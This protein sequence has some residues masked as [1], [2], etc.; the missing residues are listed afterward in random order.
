LAVSTLGRI[1]GELR[2][3]AADDRCIGVVGTVR[4]VGT[5]YA[6]I[7]L[8]RALAHDANVV[9]VDLAFNTPNLSVISNNPNAPGIAELMRETASFDDVIA[10]DLYS[11]VHIVAAGNIGSDIAALS[12]SP[13]LPTVIEALAQSY[14]HVVMDVGSISDVAA[15]HFVPLASHVMLVAADP[16][17]AVTR[18][19]RER[20]LEAGFSDV[21]VVAGGAQAAAA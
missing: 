19:V 20:L 1:A 3:A 5:T 21:T 7:T 12:S 15:A 17:S 11:R 2:R 6:A 18:T 16:A 8:A 14:D 13:T 10:R 4:G 9:L